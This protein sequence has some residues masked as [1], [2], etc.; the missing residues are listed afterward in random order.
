VEVKIEDAQGE[1][2]YWMEVEVSKEGIVR[3]F[4]QDAK[5][6]NQGERTSIHGQKRFRVSGIGWDDGAIGE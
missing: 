1:V 4:A 3:V 2:Q 6:M 5:E